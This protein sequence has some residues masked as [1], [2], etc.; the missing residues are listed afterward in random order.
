MTF[1]TFL[2]KNK[3]CVIGREKRRAMNVKDCFI[4][5]RKKTGAQ[6]GLTQK[7]LRFSTG[8]SSFVCVNKWN[9]RWNP[10]NFISKYMILLLL[11][12]FLIGSIVRKCY[13]CNV[14]WLVIS[15]ESNCPLV[16]PGTVSGMPS[17]EV[18]LKD[19]SPYLREF[20]RKPRKTPNG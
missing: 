14:G 9:L 19:P 10:V 4:R 18:F 13:S 17:V 12:D 5:E 20:W 8:N 11:W 7:W 6:Y 3:N 2:Q 1:L 15:F 16:G